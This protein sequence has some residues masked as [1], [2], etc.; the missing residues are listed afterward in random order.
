MLQC[1]EMYE[2]NL[3]IFFYLFK[4]NRKQLNTPH[5]LNC[6]SNHKGYHHT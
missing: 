5:S 4:N 1:M 2:D 3:G 6:E